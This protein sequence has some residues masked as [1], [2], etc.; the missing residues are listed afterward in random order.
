MGTVI[1]RGSTPTIY[2][3]PSNGMNVNELGEP[4]VSISQDLTYIP[5]DV[6][7]DVANNRLV[8]TL[9]EEDSLEL[10]EGVDTYIQA[11][12]DFGDGNVVRFPIHRL[13]VLPTLME[14][15]S[16]EY[17]EPEEEI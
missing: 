17:S 15:I 6:E 16:F 4:Y 8:C 12:Y 10:V 7:K 5:L 13:T 14:N 9:S 1:Y 3:S 11:V 2:I